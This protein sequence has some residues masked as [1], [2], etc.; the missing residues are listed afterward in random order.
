MVKNKKL[1]LVLVPLVLIGFFIFYKIIGPQIFYIARSPEYVPSGYTLTQHYQERQTK[2]GKIF[3]SKL[4]KEDREIEITQMDKF[5]WTC[6]GPEKTIAETEICYLKREGSDP[7]YDLIIYNKYQSTIQIHT[8]DK[9][10]NDEDLGK[11][12]VNF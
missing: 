6:N 7:K 12:I 5:S 4:I 1:I 2:S 3:V 8:N 10:L 9:K 11:I